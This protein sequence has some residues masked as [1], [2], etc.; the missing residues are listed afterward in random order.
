[1]GLAV[2]FHGPGV[3]AALGGGR[4]EGF[5]QQVVADGQPL[6]LVFGEAGVVGQ[7]AVDVDAGVGELPHVHGRRLAHVGDLLEVRGHPLELGI[8]AAR[9]R[10]GIAQRVDD[11][12]RL[13]GRLPGGDQ[14]PVGA[15]QP[16]HIEGGA[17]RVG[18]DG[19][20]GGVG[21]FGRA[22]Q[23]F[24]GQLVVFHLAVELEAGV[25]HLL[26]RLHGG[27]CNFGLKV[28]EGHG[29]AVG[30]LFAQ[31]G[32][33][34]QLL[35]GRVQLFAQLVGQ[36]GRALF[37]AGRVEGRFTADAESCICHCVQSPLKQAR[38]QGHRLK[39]ST[40]IHVCR[41]GFCT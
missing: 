20:E 3:A 16:R 1:M 8:A 10:N 14:Q 17:G 29:Q 2:G 40:Q 38:A 18:L 5:D 19:V 28:A 39:V 6:H 31:A 36:A 27:L 22:Q 35:P 21:R 24:K 33:Q 12:A 41:P 37:S 25:D 15:D 30:R 32:K 4:L 11:L 26:H 23:V 34:A 13:L 9:S 7:D